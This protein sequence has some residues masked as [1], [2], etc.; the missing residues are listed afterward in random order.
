MIKNSSY[1]SKF[2]PSLLCNPDT[3]KLNAHIQESFDVFFNDNISEF[4]EYRLKHEFNKIAKFKLNDN[5][6]NYLNDDVLVKVRDPQKF[7]GTVKSLIKDKKFDSV[8]NLLR[9]EAIKIT[10]KDFNKFLV[11]HY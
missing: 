1:I 11:K 4:G 7:E 3:Y 9:H 5:F 2:R 8:Y 6:T 10:K